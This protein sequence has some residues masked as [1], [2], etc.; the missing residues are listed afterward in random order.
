MAF[1]GD[2]T[3]VPMLEDVLVTLA[4]L[5]SHTPP[6]RPLL[7]SGLG[8]AR[9]VVSLLSREQPALRMLGLRLLAICLRQ[10]PALGIGLGSEP[11]S[12][13]G[14]GAETAAAA[15]G[16][17]A[18][19]GDALATFPLTAPTREALLL[20]ACAGSPSGQCGLAGVQAAGSRLVCASMHWWGEVQRRFER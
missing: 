14:S 16:L 18:A 9:L 2:C 3:D 15:Q 1:I 11:G 13:G 12:P 4:A 8:G 20:I 6:G 7:L 5:L 19:V 17:W 10:V